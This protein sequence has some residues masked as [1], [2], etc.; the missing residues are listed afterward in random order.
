MDFKNCLSSKDFV[1][2]FDNDTQAY[3]HT[4]YYHYTS[5]SKVNKIL[6]SKQ[7]WLS[8]FSKYA[9][10]LNE[11]KTYEKLDNNIF[12]LCFST[13]TSESLP[14]WYL[15]SGIDGCGVRIGLKKKTMRQLLESSTF[16]LQP[17]ESEPPYKAYGKQIEL[18]KEEYKLLFRDIIYIGQDSQKAGYYRAKYNGQVINNL[19]KEVID[20]IRGDY[21]RFVK[22]LIWFYE[23]ET[24]IQVEI[25]NKTLLDPAKNYVV[26]LNLDNIY[27]DISVRLAPEFNDIST[28]VFGKYRGINNWVCTKLQKS[29]YAGQLK[30]GLADKMCSE[31]EKVKKGGNNKHNY[32]PNINSK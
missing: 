24:R 29:E 25:I 32:I 11:K 27:N 5:L 20:G 2:F 31:C 30:M 1:N 7:I 18:K 12:S 23:K 3:K 4:N 21:Q 17:V 22:D 10:D 28:E 15:Y 19:S 6:E 8:S 16:L 14:L 9:N 26:A 13:G